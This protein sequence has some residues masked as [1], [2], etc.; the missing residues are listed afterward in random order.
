MPIKTFASLIVVATL[1][2]ACV[3]GHP[4]R[5]R[6]P[7]KTFSEITHE[8]MTGRLPAEALGLTGPFTYEALLDYEIHLSPARK[9]SVTTLS[10][11]DRWIS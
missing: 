4:E 9:T 3:T 2:A 8:L 7:A 11:G 1:S 10:C 5:V 6:S